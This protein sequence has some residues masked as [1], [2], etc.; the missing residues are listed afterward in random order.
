MDNQEIKQRYNRALAQARAGDLRAAQATLQGVQHPKARALLQKIEAKLPAK[1][2]KRQR[3]LPIIGGVAAVLVGV[4]IAVLLTGRGDAEVSDV[5]TEED[6]I[7]SV[8]VLVPND[9]TCDEAFVEAWWLQHRTMSGDFSE[10]AGI[11]GMS[12]PGERLNNRLVRMREIRDLV[13]DPPECSTDE[14]KSAI[15]EVVDAMDVILE[16]GTAYAENNNQENT[17]RISFELPEAIRVLRRASLDVNN[18][19]ASF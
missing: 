19:I 11:V 13:A 1:T 17:E 12:S 6:E 9:G 16:M 7:T 3:W 18:E 2:P 4:V 8:E 14:F 15:V 10:Q 5:Q